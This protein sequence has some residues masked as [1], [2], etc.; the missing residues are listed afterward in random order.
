MMLQISDNIA[1]DVLMREAGGSAYVGSYADPLGAGHAE[2]VLAQDGRLR[3]HFGEPGTFSG[4]MVHW[5]HD[6]FRLYRDGGDG[7]TGSS[8]VTFT[9]EPELGVAVMDLGFMGQYRRKR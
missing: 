9:I 4:D 8:F 6:V 7:Q 3:L 2:V 1:T 5:N